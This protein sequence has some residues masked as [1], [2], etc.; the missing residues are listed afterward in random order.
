MFDIEKNLLQNISSQMPPG[1][2]K[3]FFGLLILLENILIS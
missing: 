2:V 3:F 1:F